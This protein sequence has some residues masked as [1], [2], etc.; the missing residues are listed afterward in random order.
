MKDLIY[1]EDA[2]AELRATIDYYNDRQSGL[3]VEFFDEVRAAAELV[4]QMPGAFT[5]HGRHGLRVCRV[6]RFPFA[7]YYQE[8]SDAIWIA[9]VAHNRRRPDYWRDRRP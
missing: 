9:A 5:L 3:G 6:K 8:M 7:L 2:E 4:R 1:H